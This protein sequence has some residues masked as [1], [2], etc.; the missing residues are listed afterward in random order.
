MVD[1][2]FQV[3]GKVD[4]PSAL[5]FSGPDV[6]LVCV[7]RMNH[8]FWLAKRAEYYGHN[9]AFDPTNYVELVIPEEFVEFLIPVGQEM[10]E[11]LE[12]TA[13]VPGD[14]SSREHQLQ[15]LFIILQNIPGSKK[16]MWTHVL[17]KLHQ[18]GQ[19]NVQF[20]TKG[21]L[22]TVMK[23]AF[24]MG[25]IVTPFIR[26]WLEGWLDAAIRDQVLKAN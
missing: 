22:Q 17:Q 15:L 13:T 23:K 1:Q 19:F 4:P 26:Q 5:S 21:E 14:T 2:L 18:M 12:A 3:Q 10:A 7:V 11:F 25:Q 20:T 8:R 24:L 6:H 9:K 16:K